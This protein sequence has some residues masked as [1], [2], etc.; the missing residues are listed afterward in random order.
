MIGS[1][2]IYI[3][4]L[5]IIGVWPVC[6]QH[7]PVTPVSKD[8]LNDNSREQQMQ[9]RLESYVQLMSSRKESSGH[10]NVLVMPTVGFHPSQLSYGLMIGVMKRTGGYV[11]A[12]YSFSK[13]PTDS[14]DCND[15][16]I[17]E[18]DG[19][20]RWYTGRTEKKRFAVTGGLVQRLWKPLYVY[21]G[22][23]YGTRVQVW[24]T[25]S[26]TW[27]KNKDHSYAGVEAEIGGIIAF[28]HLVFSLGA[29]TNSFEYL[30]GNIGIG[31]I[32]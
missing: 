9:A 28:R 29:Q 3:C 32:F 10:V 8:T 20:V 12:A 18:E 17:S 27:G 16:G 7:T 25:V 4:F 21:A 14:F 30:E 11:K 5:W 13:V 22:A 24:E 19:R 2:Y 15:E 1:K 23:G 6:A 26:G 31:V